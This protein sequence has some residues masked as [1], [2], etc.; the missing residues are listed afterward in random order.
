MSTVMIIENNAVFRQTLINLIKSRFGFLKFQEATNG[1][2]AFNKIKKSIPDI[3]FINITLPLE[4]GL[5]ITKK[6]REIYPE[7][8]LVSMT[9]YDLTEYREAAEQHGA[10]CFISKSSF[11][12]SEMFEFVESVLS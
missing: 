6:I 3:F 1:E 11:D 5:K 12:V 4:S 7:V 8:F 10:N 2:E 9:S